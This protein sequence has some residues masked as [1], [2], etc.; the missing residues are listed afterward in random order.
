MLVL[1]AVLSNELILQMKCQMLLFRYRKEF[2][3]IRGGV[4]ATLWL[5]I[6]EVRTEMKF[7][8]ASL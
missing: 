4:G 1:L 2:L 5:W 7:E 3:Y 6:F 8:P